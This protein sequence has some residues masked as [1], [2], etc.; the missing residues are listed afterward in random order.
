MRETR[1]A[2]IGTSEYAITCLREVRILAFVFALKTVAVRSTSSLVVADVLD[3][4]SL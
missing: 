1:G 2:L 4:R 3:E